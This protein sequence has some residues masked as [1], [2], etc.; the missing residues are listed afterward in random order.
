MENVQIY[1]VLLAD[2]GDTGKS[3][4]SLPKN[5]IYLELLGCGVLGSFNYERIMYNKEDFS[6]SGRLGFFPACLIGFPFSGKTWIF[7]VLINAQFHLSN[8]TTFEIGAGTSLIEDVHPSIFGVGN[9]GFRFS[10]KNKFLIKIAITPIIWREHYYEYRPTYKESYKLKVFPS[11]G[12]SIGY[13][14]GK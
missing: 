3:F 12:L 14:F 9:V 1:N 10:I 7:P 11:V 6:L 5:S 2:E 8:V 4:I 13:S